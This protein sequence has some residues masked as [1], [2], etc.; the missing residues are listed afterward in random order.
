M[1]QRMD[2]DNQIQDYM[3]HPVITR[4]PSIAT[5]PQQ[6]RRTFQR[7]RRRIIMIGICMDLYSACT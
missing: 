3:S 5:P 1:S 7:E 2:F 6:Q 4:T